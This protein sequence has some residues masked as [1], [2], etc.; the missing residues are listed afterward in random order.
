SEASPLLLNINGD[1]IA[2]EIAAAIGAD[3]LILLT[4]VDG[5]RNEAGSLLPCLSPGEAEALMDSGVASGGMI[6][7]IKA[8][9]RAVSNAK[10]SCIIIDGRRKHALLD[11]VITGGSGTVIKPV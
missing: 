7:K 10:T 6:P 11:E 3:K 4:D 1:T 2:G 5:I 9:L 8:C